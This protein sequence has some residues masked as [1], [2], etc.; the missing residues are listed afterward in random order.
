MLEHAIVAPAPAVT[1]A[2]H[3]CARAIRKRISHEAFRGQLRA[4]EIAQ[5]D[6][7]AA[8]PEF[9]RHA[10]GTG[11]PVPVEHPHRGVGDRLADRDALLRHAQACAGR[12]DRGLGGSIHV[13]QFAAAVAQGHCK[14][15]RQALA[16]GKRLEALATGPACRDQQPP[17]RRRGLHAGGAAGFQQPAQLVAIPRILAGGDDHPPAHRQRQEQFRDRH[18]ERHDRD[19]DQAVIGGKSGAALHAAQQVHQCAMRHHHALRPAGRSRGVDDVG[20]GVR[21][22]AAFV[23]RKRLDPIPGLRIEILV[24]HQGIAARIGNRAQQ[25]RAADDRLQRGI[26]DHEV[27]AI[28]GISGIERH[29]GGACLQDPEHAGEQVRLAFQVDAH[30]GAASHATIA[31]CMCDRVGTPFERRIT[32]FL[33]AERDG[34]AIRRGR[35]MRR[36]TLVHEQIGVVFRT[37][38]LQCAQCLPFARRNPVQPVPRAIGSRDGRTQQRVQRIH[39]APDA[40]G[41]E[42]VGVVVATQQQAS[43]ILRNPGQEQVEAVVSG[44]ARRQACLRRPCCIAARRRLEAEEHARQWP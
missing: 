44:C 8:D 13:P 28:L 37:R 22:R 29:E 39:P 12:P 40:F 41:I 34:D 1:G 19:R 3:A 30:Q 24:Q 20:R 2:I 35:G 17:A 10:G 21:C 43:V 18:V 15:L 6:T 36:E 42:Q 16:A 9:A 38:R 5:G 11:L 32:Q 23:R 7:V 31:Q 25:D 4:I 33:R 26:R 14:V 27:E